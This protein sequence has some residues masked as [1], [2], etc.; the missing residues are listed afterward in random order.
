MATNKKDRMFMALA[1]YMVVILR[2]IFPSTDNYSIVYMRPWT[3]IAKPQA[4]S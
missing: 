4:V 3:E 1:E 2:I